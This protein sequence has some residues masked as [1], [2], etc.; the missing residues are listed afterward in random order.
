MVRSG[1]LEEFGIFSSA[2]VITERKR[3]EPV[4]YKYDK[5]LYSGYKDHHNRDGP[6]F[7][8]GIT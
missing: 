7:T 3:E 8:F 2:H 6:L 5:A 1:N 4:R